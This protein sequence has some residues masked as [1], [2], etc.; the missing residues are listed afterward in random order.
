MRLRNW[1]E[2]QSRNRMLL[3]SAPLV[4]IAAASAVAAFGNV[5]LARESC[6]T[7]REY[8]D[9]VGSNRQRLAGVDSVL[10]GFDLE[11]PAVVVRADSEYGKTEPNRLERMII[12]LRLQGVTAQQMHRWLTAD[13]LLTPIEQKESNRGADVAA[14]IAKLRSHEADT[15][16]IASL[17]RAMN[18][19]TDRMHDLNLIAP[20]ADRWAEQC[21]TR[22]RGLFLLP[23]I[24]ALATLALV[25]AWLWWVRRA[26][27]AGWR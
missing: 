7:A 26:P 11:D 9:S 24:F 3:L 18:V 21:A 12:A 17:R 4:L 14:Q 19:A 5:N 16:Y 1:L 6:S 10:R 15:V 27:T 8:A 20:L 13:L 22:N 23:A 25:L 2:R